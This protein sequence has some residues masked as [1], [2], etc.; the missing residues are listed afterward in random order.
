MRSSSC[1]TPAPSP[2]AV[3]YREFFAFR[4]RPPAPHTLL[5][6]YGNLV[7]L[8]CIF[9][10][11]E[12]AGFGRLSRPGKTVE[13]HFQGACEERPLTVLTGLEKLSPASVTPCPTP[14]HPSTH[15]SFNRDPVGSTACVRD[16]GAHT[17]PRCVWCL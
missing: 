10:L 15:Q 3:T 1:P 9:K 14:I 12:I 11:G 4:E 13:V 2:I 5:L 8:A 6:E 17:G 7:L 16:L